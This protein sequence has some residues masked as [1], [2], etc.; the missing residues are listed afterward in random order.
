MATIIQNYEGRDTRGANIQ[1]ARDMIA[2]ARRIRN[3]H[4]FTFDNYC[5]RHIKAN[6]K[7][8][9]YNAYVDP[10]S[11]VN[12]FLYG[13]RTDTRLSTQLLLIKRIILNGDNTKNNLQN[14]M[15]TFKDT[16]R[17]LGG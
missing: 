14:A 16:M 4:K 9:R 17:N 2:I 11:Q 3:S 8:D 13:I 15:N 1:R 6:S 5:N 12:L 7:L 10:E